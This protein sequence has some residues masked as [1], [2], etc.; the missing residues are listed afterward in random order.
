MSS[1]WLKNGVDTGLLLRYEI[2]D[3]GTRVISLQW[4][5]PRGV[6][7]GGLRVIMWKY[8]F[9]NL[10]LLQEIA[11]CVTSNYSVVSFCVSLLYPL[12][13]TGTFQ[14]RAFDLH[15]TMLQLPRLICLSLWHLGLM[16]KDNLFVLHLSISYEVQLKMHLKG[17][18]QS[19]LSILKQHLGRLHWDLVKG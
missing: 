2:E 16:P 6:F 13:S 1:A 9:F 17:K 4:G 15:S 14:H 7:V 11:L 3:D 5:C 8:W 19:F 18:L 12:F 10:H